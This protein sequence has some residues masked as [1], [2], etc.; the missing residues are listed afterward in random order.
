MRKRKRDNSD[1]REVFRLMADNSQDI[2]ALRTL[3]GE[4]LF[5][6]PASK[7]ILGYES[8][9]LKG[10]YRQNFIHPIDY[11]VTEEQFSKNMSSEKIHTY[12]YRFKH[13]NGSYIWLE[14]TFQLIHNG[15]QILSISR[16]I[17][18]RFA[19]NQ[20][21]EEND[22]KYRLFVKESPNAILIYQDGVWV[23]VNEPGYKLLGATDQNEVLGKNAFDFIHADS[24]QIVQ[25]QKMLVELGNITDFYEERWKTIDGKEIDVEV[26]AIPIIFE[27]QPAVHVV[28]NDISM[29]K[30][31]NELAQ[32]AEKFALVG[33]LAAGIAH[34]IRNPL[35]SING[36]LKLMEDEL[37][38][39][40]YLEIVWSELSRIELITSEL[41][42]LAKP[43]VSSFKV[44]MVQTLLSHVVTLLL[45]QANLLN[46]ELIQNYESDPIWIKCDEYQLRQVFINIIKNSI[47]AMPNGGQITISVKKDAEE[48]VVC[49]EDQGQGISEENLQKV[50][51]PFFTTKEKGTG[52][53]MMVSFQIIE[54][55]QGSI[56]IK[57]QLGLGTTFIIHL[58]IFIK[59][60]F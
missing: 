44:Q 13:K 32:N 53:G 10:K 1:Q 59:D 8:D 6:S 26:K 17:S 39:K 58:P 51:K 36:F 28:I 18:H 31:I 33:Q 50:G 40:R 25:K 42:L 4:Y 3:E 15:K 56:H 60:T 49:I 24:L 54:N 46:I 19:N 20:L 47:E 55:H 11:L 41:L 5:I 21:C 45:P 34:E 43:H 9:E 16:D 29:R 12:T 35:T 48:A 37:Q 7:K 38:D 27:H 30:K 23:D 22:Q 52:L 57:S 14:S 2:I